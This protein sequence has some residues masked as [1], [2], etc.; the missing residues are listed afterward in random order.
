V[1]AGSGDLRQ[2]PLYRRPSVSRPWRAVFEHRLGIVV[3]EPRGAAHQNDGRPALTRTV[4]VQATAADIYRA[5]DLR[6]RLA[7]A[8]PLHL[9]VQSAGDQADR[10]QTCARD[11]HRLH[12]HN[13]AL[14]RR[15]DD[16]LSSAVPAY[17]VVTRTASDKRWHPACCRI[18]CSILL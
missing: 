16:R 1:P 12:P 7:V 3:E 8:S 11:Q 6:K 13:N 17:N 4:D 2:F 15:A 5:A 18:L 14:L 10:N 9:L